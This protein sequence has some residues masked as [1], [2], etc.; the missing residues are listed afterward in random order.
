MAVQLARGNRL[1][2]HVVER[3]V[4]KDV[5]ELKNYFKEIGLTQEVIKL[6]NKPE[7]MLYWNARAKAK[8]AEQ[9]ENP[10]ETPKKAKAAPPFTSQPF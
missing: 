4:Q 3:L 8:K 5:G 10:E 9:L 7:L 1:K 2:A 6:G